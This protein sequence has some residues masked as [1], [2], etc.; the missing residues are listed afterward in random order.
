MA[1]FSNIHLATVE[2]KGRCRDP[3]RS[4]KQIQMGYHSGLNQHGISGGGEKWSGS[5]YFLK[6]EPTSLP[7]SL[8]VT[9]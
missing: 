4:D 1:C 6:T 8:D 5:Q 3:S 9:L 2:R 7:D